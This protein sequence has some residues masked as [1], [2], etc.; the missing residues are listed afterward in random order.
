MTAYNKK[1]YRID[2]VDFNQNASS[3]FHLIKE[4]RD[5]TYAEYY[6]TRYQQTIRV[7]SQPLLVSR[8]TRRDINRGD[9]ASIFLVPE[10]CGMTG[11]SD[12]HRY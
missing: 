7:L 11:L 10:L 3:T 1:T 4:D 5:I 12:E 2:D 9:N 8:P 6:R